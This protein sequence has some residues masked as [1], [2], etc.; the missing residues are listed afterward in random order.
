MS[1]FA[2][3]LPVGMPVLEDAYRREQLIETRDSL[4]SFT[5][6]PLSTDVYSARDTFFRKSDGSL[7]FN[8]RYHLPAG[9]GYIQ[10]LPIYVHTQT[11]SILPFDWN[12]GSLIPSR[13]NQKQLTGGV[14]AKFGPLSIQLKPE[15]VYAENKPFEEFPEEQHDVTWARYYRS[16]YNVAEITGRFGDGPYNEWSWGQSRVSLTFDPVSV[17]LSN[18]NLWWGPGRRSSLVMSNNAPGFKHITLNTSRPVKTGIGSFEGQLIA[19]KLENSGI[20]PPEVNRVYQGQTLYIPKRQDDRYLSGMILTYQPKWLEG[21]FLGAT[22]V[23]QMYTDVAGESPADFLPFLRPFEKEA[24]ADQRDRYSS[25][26]F[27]WIMREAKAEI[28]AEYGHHGKTALRELVYNPDK[29]AAYLVGLRKIFPLINSAGEYF[30]ASIEL[31]QLQQTAIPELGGWYTSETIR[32]GYTHRGAVLGAGI[33]PGSNLQSVEVSWFR[34]LKRIGLQV[35]RYVH[36]NDFYYQAYNDPP[37][38][39]KHYV[40]M[41]FG[42]SV[43]WDFKNLFLNA[44]GNVI[45]TL[46]YQ[47]V[48]YNRPKDYFVTGWDRVNYSFSLGLG[49]RF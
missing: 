28:Y 42:A 11:N 3:S 26:F 43:D 34:G 10:L 35:E 4:V 21:L 36:N 16:Y 9:K 25:L 15:Y 38:Y 12:D 8:G 5:I 19:G 32:Q 1:A 6:R 20:L 46:N 44:S 29:N 39:R 49:Y 40:D 24:A 7:K 31:T 33:G 14:F 41:S 48:L 18:E 30:Q 22:R 2:Q 13:G 17:G 23:S 37:D 47:Y 45:R 27:R